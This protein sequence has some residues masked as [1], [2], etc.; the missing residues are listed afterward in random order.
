[1]FAES[2]DAG[3]VTKQKPL[4]ICFFRN[5]LLVVWEARTKGSQRIRCI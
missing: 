1:M 3:I 4:C 5:A 2:I